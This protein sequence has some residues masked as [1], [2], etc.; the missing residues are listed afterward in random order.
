MGPRRKTDIPVADAD[1]APD[2]DSSEAATTVHGA[3]ASNA[4]DVSTVREGRNA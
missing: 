1:A 4:N 2:V 3:S